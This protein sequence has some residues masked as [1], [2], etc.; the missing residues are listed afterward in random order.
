MGDSAKFQIRP[1]TTD[2][3]L[4]A[5]K[6]LFTAYANSLGIDLAFQNFS[7]EMD[8][9]PGQYSP[10]A[11]GALLIAHD[12][13]GVAIGCVGLRRLP[14]TSRDEG[15]CEMK[16]LYCSPSARGLGLGR[17]LADRVIECA[18][19]E[20][21]KEI[22][23]DTLPDMVGAR[24]LY[25]KLGFLETEAYYDTPIEGTLFLSKVLCA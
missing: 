3:D 1:V 10:T 2:L 6:E 12:L 23:L 16:R 15:I 22:R 5:V 13:K 11:G 21:Y 14:S 7:K 25:K 24:A 9:M 19:R 17:A 4:L 20:G 8:S 18:I